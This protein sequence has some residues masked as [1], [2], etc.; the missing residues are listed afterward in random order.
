MPLTEIDLETPEQSLDGEER[1]TTKLTPMPKVEEQGTKTIEFSPVG[2]GYVIT[3]NTPKS[4]KDDSQTKRK[5]FREKFA[6]MVGMKPREKEELTTMTEKG[7]TFG[8][9]STITTEAE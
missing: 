3:N 8:T 1:K 5:S 6:A 7:K 4:I 9:V 2:K